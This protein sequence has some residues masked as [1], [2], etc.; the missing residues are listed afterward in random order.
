MNVGG[1]GPWPSDLR[2]VVSDEEGGR[3]GATFALIVDPRAGGTSIAAT[4]V[5][6]SGEGFSDAV[7]ATV[8]AGD[9]RLLEFDCRN[10]A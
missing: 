10:R 9:V 2:V 3:E 5:A 8:I 4:P 6:T 1:D 7:E